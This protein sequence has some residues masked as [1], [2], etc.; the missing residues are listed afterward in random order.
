LKPAAVIKF[1]ANSLLLAHLDASVRPALG[2]EH[3]SLPWMVPINLRG[4]STST[5]DTEN[6]VS[7]VDVIIAPEDRVLDVHNQ[8]LNRLAQGEHRANFLLMQL[9]RFL[10]QER[11]MRMLSHSRSKPQGNIGVF[12]N[13]GSWDSQM[14]IPTRDSWVF[15]PPLVTGQRLAAGCVTFQNRLG[16]MLHTRPDNTG[17]PDLA[18][19]WMG[20]W[21]NRITGSR[22][23]SG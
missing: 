5:D 1:T 20:G 8:I 19:H 16:L 15:C 12:S 9:G 10:G 23:Q 21:V 14:P 17:L 6:Q 3:A 2:L 4:G 22:E 11:K 18:S 7:C 13:L